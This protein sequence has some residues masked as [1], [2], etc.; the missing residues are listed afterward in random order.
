MESEEMN[1][2]C[3]ILTFNLSTH[4]YGMLPL[5]APT[6][7]WIS[8]ISHI[9]ET[10]LTTIQG[11]LAL[12]PSGTSSTS[13]SSCNLKPPSLFR[14]SA[15]PLSLLVRFYLV[16]S[17][18][19]VIYAKS[20]RNSL[21]LWNPSITRKLSLSEYPRRFEWLE[22]FGFG[23]DPISEDYKII[24]IS[25]A[26]DTSLFYEVKTGAW[27]EIA[28]PKPRCLDVSP[29]TCSLEG[30]WH[31]PVRYRIESEEMRL[32]CSILT[33][34][35]STHVFGM[36]PLPTP[37]S[38]W[39][40]T[41]LTTIQ[42]SLALISYHMK[43]DDTWIR[44]RR[45]SSWSVVFKLNTVKLFIEGA[46]Q[47]QLRPNNNGDLLLI[48][49]GQFSQEVHVYNPKTGELSK[50]VDFDVASGLINFHQCIETLHLL[51]MGE[52]LCKTT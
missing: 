14:A 6:W 26:R 40:T 29:C 16:I 37:A 10:R 32:T 35:L 41:G 23:F 48:I 38:D 51:D 21:I 45:D 47:L 34:N 5:P 9:M 11:S 7:R 30:V 33:F 50:V 2:S 8:P 25:Y 20:C 4:V 1:I 49:A 36:I 31:W 39:M 12:I 52:T 13:K 43:F 27:C 19:Q 44:V 46:F 15:G 42:G 24:M 3:S 18:C 28:S 22:A 17:R